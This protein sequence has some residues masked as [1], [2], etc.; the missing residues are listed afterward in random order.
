MEFDR[1]PTKVSRIIAIYIRIRYIIKYVLTFRTITQIK[2]PV[3]IIGCGHSGTSILLSILGNHSK[4]YSVPKESYL[5]FENIRNIQ[6]TLCLWIYQSKSSNKE[7]ILEKTPRHLYCV[8]SILKIFPHSK[9]ICI[10]RDCRDTVISFY[11][12]GFSP[13]DGYGRWK[14]GNLYIH[15]YKNSQ[16]I[17]NVKYELMVKDPF[18]FFNGI[19]DFLKIEYENGI[20]SN[21]GRKKSWEDFNSD[22]EHNGIPTEKQNAKRRHFQMSQDIMNYNGDWKL[23]KYNEV[24]NFLECKTDYKVVSKLI[25]H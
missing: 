23:S 8:D 3:F 18:K 2:Y 6:K 4:V 11:K 19:T 1:E 25:N 5:F 10:R 22:T 13:E 16:S 21:K 9:F 15:N 7:I 24:M 20:L 12:R 17:L 14:S